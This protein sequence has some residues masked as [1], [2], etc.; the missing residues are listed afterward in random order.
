M[1]DDKTVGAVY[2]FN[3]DKRLKHMC[4]SSLKLI[5]V[6]RLGLHQEPTQKIIAQDKSI[7]FGS[8]IFGVNQNLAIS[9]AKKG[10][11]M[12]FGVTPSVRLT[13][14]WSNTEWL[15]L[16]Q[17]FDPL[18]H[19]KRRKFDCEGK[20]NCWRLCIKYE[21]GI[22]NENLDFLII[23]HLD[24]DMVTKRLF[25]GLSYSEFLFFTDLEFS[26]FRLI[27]KNH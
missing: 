22:K 4:T 16:D 3:G 19:L 11:V 9:D 24:T 21:G 25:G 26:L 5:F 1:I 18:N 6:F 10:N 17:P 15:P 12:I 2:I 27:L 7:Q 13:A 20:S 8:A 23:S 14:L